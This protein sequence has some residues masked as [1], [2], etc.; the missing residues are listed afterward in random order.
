M[1]TQC[2]AHI[3]HSDRRSDPAL[4]PDCGGLTLFPLVEALPSTAS[5]GIDGAPEIHLLAADPDKHLVE[6]PAPVRDRPSRVQP[7]CNNRP[8][9]RHPPTDGL[10]RHLD[11]AL[12]E[13]VLDV[14]VAQ[15]EAE[16]HPHGAGSRRMESGKQHSQAG[17]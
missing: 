7:M 8:E 6:V 15:G 11:A 16:I 9:R 4:S 12:G 5:I 10:V 17:S 2:P 14:P 13:Q 3:R 1:P